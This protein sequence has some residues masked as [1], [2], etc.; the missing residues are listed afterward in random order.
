MAANETI[1]RAAGQR[2]APTKIDY[3]GWLEG[4]SNVSKVLVEKRKRREK[5]ETAGYKAVDANFKKRKTSPYADYMKNKSYE[6]VKNGEDPTSFF[7]DMNADLDDYAEL[8]ELAEFTKNWSSGSDP[9]FEN[10]MNSLG[11]ELYENSVYIKSGDKDVELNIDTWLDPRDNRFKI[12]NIDGTGYVTPGEILA[13]AKTMARTTDGVEIKEIHNK[14]KLGV[15][16]IKGSNSENN[17]ETRKDIALDDLDNLF[18]NGSTN[19]KG[20]VLITANRIKTSAMFDQKYRVRNENQVGSQEVDFIDYYLTKT[21]SDGMPLVPEELAAQYG[22]FQ[23][24]YLTE[25]DSKVK[26]EMKKKFAAS[27]MEE[28][29]NIEEDFKQ[30]FGMIL[31]RYQEPGIIAEENETNVSNVGTQVGTQVGNIARN[32]PKTKQFPLSWFTR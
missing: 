6:M 17:Y 30:F 15:K 12:L 1:I 27:I 4:L 32:T 9:L 16:N 29:D 3:S 23:K 24:L 21:D 11:D 14:F 13:M 25:T 28:D 19:S 7:Q 2:Y 22:E 5:K 26:E 8:Q 18:R 10:Y 31:D 20:E